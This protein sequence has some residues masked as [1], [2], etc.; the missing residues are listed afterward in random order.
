M[1]DTGIERKRERESERERDSQRERQRES[2]RESAR[3]T[4]VITR[5]KVCFLRQQYCFQPIVFILPLIFAFVQV[6]QCGLV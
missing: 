5:N 6:L 4:I 2:E 3:D 1:I